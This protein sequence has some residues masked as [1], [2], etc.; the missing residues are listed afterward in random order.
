MS[1]ADS[2]IK[3]LKAGET[4]SFRPKGRSMEPIVMS[5]Q[6]CTVIPMNASC[7]VAVGD[8]VLCH[9]AGSDYLHKVLAI[10]DGKFLI[11]NNKGRQNGWTKQVFGK[12]V[13]VEP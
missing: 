4:V 8:I 13:K 3:K 5:E 9:V 11:G 6:L 12:L 10:T 1:W 2:Q 7:D